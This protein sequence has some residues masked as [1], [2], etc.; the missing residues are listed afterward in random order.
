MF[1]QSSAGEVSRASYREEYSSMMYTGQG[2][3]H[4]RAQ[5]QSPFKTASGNRQGAQSPGLFNRAGTM[6]ARGKGSVGS[7]D[8]LRCSVE[9][10][11][12]PIVVVNRRSSE[13]LLN[14]LAN[15]YCT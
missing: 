15:M 9:S 2:S 13:N 1:N 12:G 10:D 11:S 6:R 3:P 8:L 4:S 5:A 7:I 14:G